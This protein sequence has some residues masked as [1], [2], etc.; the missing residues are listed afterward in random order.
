MIV[1]LIDLPVQI[2][3]ED[4]SLLKDMEN[5]R[6]LTIKVAFEEG[7]ININTIKLSCF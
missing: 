7:F 2:R 6:P 5:L 1:L 4:D 3:V